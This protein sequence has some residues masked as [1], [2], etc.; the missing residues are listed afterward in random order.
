MILAHH[1]VEAAGTEEVRQGRP[2]TEALSTGVVKE[3]RG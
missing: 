3:R 2:I 1:L